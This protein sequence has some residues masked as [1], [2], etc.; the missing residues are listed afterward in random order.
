M[1]QVRGRLDHRE[2]LVGRDRREV[3]L[4]DERLR[5][6]HRLR[7]VGQGLLEPRGVVGLHDLLRL[8]D[9]GAR[10]DCGRALHEG[11]LAF[12]KI[13]LSD[14]VNLVDREP[15]LAEA[16]ELPELRPA[17]ADP[18]F[19]PWEDV[20]LDP[21]PVRADRLPRVRDGLLEPASVGTREVLLAGRLDPLAEAGE[22]G[23]RLEG[24]FR[25]DL[26]G[27]TD[28]ALRLL[29]ERGGTLEPS[30]DALEP[31]RQ[32]REGAHEEREEGVSHGLGALRHGLPEAEFLGPEGPEPERVR[33]DAPVDALSRG[34]ALPVDRLDA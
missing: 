34:E 12:P 15:K 14:R 2:L 18:V 19:R 32:R 5:V 10:P 26:D 22:P 17:D 24:D 25:P 28:A 30:D 23:R 13:L 9:G 11:F 1:T 8:L 6:R 20:G 27:R 3:V 21:L 31:T 29:E 33:A 7:R 16:D 4:A